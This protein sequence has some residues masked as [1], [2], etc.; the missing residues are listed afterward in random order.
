VAPFHVT[1]PL[2]NY[3]QVVLTKSRNYF[4]V[5]LID[6]WRAIVSGSGLI[7]YQLKADRWVLNPRSSVK[8]FA[9]RGKPMDR[10]FPG[11]TPGFR[12]IGKMLSLL[13]GDF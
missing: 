12:R 5:N 6:F 3:S 10:E 8:F 1:S 2:E 7:G 9:F 4:R 11:K 13:T